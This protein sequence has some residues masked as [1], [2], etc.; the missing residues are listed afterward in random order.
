MAKG[1]GVSGLGREQFRSRHLKEARM[2]ALALSGI[3]KRFQ[4]A[5]KNDDESTVF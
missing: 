1:K 5:V 4:K 3:G 2:N